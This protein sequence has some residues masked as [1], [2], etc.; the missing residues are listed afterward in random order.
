MSL[1]HVVHFVYLPSKGFADA[2]IAA[3]QAEYG[4]ENVTVLRFP[5]IKHGLYRLRRATQKAYKLARIGLGLRNAHYYGLDEAFYDPMLDELRALQARQ[6]FD[7][8]C[9]EYVSNSKAFQAFPRDVLK[10]LD[11]LDKFVDRHLQKGVK[12]PLISFTAQEEG[13][14]LRRADV[15]IAIQQME[16][17]QFMRQIGEDGTKVATI[18]H[19]LDL[20]ARIQSHEPAEVLFIGS[21]NPPNVFSLTDFINTTLPL[22][23]EL[24]P[25]FR[26]FVV[27]G[28]CN[29][30]PSASNI[31]KL[32]RVANL[33]EVYK[34]AP[35]LINPI[36]VGTGMNIKLLEAMA[37]GI[38][39]ISTETG[40]RGLT[41]EFRD[42]VIIVPDLD[43]KAFARNIAELA[44]SKSAREILGAAAHQSA[45]RWNRKQLDSLED[46]FGRGPGC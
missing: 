26:I 10:V 40:A 4:Q 43:R 35:T 8:V 18:G 5:A 45:M 13:R 16:A 21:A 34:R 3:H 1:G 23:C 31:V 46:V 29:A 15:V 33:S 2:D 27:G 37:A 28:I 32:G 14:G 30:I 25:D 44:H 24:V 17:E 20:S 19:F 36:I 39:V 11:T 38:P 7:A 9:V 42:G 41:A 6:R 12:R 22:V